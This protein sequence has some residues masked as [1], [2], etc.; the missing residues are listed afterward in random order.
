MSK[1]KPNRETRGR[2]STR[3]YE[4][5][6]AIERIMASD[7]ED[8]KGQKDELA[9]WLLGLSSTTNVHVLHPKFIRAMFI[10]MCYAIREIDDDDRKKDAERDRMFIAQAINPIGTAL[11]DAQ[12]EAAGLETISRFKYDAETDKFSIRELMPVVWPAGTPRV[13][14]DVPEVLPPTIDAPIDLNLWRQ[15]RPRPILTCAVDVEGGE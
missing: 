10:E 4:Q 12:R 13:E 7:Y 1:T 11:L 5:A 9:D 14:P 8:V 2:L 6:D 3:T 15:S